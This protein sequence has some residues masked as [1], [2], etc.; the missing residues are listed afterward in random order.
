V[1]RD[2]HHNDRDEAR[3]ARDEFAHEFTGTYPGDDFIEDTW[4]WPA[5]RFVIAPAAQPERRAA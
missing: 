1:I 4:G 5:P 3:S 2:A